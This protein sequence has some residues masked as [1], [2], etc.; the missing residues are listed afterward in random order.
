M[1]MIHVH[2]KVNCL[3]KPR[4]KIKG[5]VFYLWVD[6]MDN[7]HGINNKTDKNKKLHQKRDYI[8]WYHSIDKL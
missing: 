4:L 2:L 3:Y 6:K 1:E 8:Q 7:S 5:A